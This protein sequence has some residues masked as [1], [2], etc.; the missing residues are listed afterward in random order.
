MLEA[1]D[2]DAISE[3]QIKYSAYL[4]KI[5]TNVVGNEPDAEE[6]V[7]ETFYKAWQ[8]IP[9]AKP[10]NLGAF[11]GKITRELA[12]DAFRAKKSRQ[13]T[14]SEYDEAVKELG[15]FD[16]SNDGTEQAV[17]QIFLRDAIVSFLKSVSE[18]EKNVF[19]RRYFFFDPVKE[20]A[21]MY[22]IS[23]SAV[24]VIMF[25]TRNKLKIFLEKEGYV[26]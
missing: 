25:R 23:E 12:I 24:K 6:C 15:F 18:K 21:Q 22:R 7:N 4:K 9:P 26:I 5:A 3:L 8:K 13:K 16:L 1:R 20:I 17:D 14:A 10:A 19:I 2:E 11:L